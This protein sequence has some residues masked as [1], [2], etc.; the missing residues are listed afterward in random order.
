MVKWIFDRLVSLTA[1]VL[2]SPILLALAVIVLVGN[3]WPIFFR[4]ERIG[5]Y[6]KPFSMIK[7]RSMRGSETSSVATCE[8]E[9]VTSVGRLLRR[10]KLDELP[11]LFNILKGDMSFVG[12]RPDVPGYA[13]KLE[14]DDRKM[15]EMKP[16]LTGVATLKYRNEDDLLSS[17]AN[18]KEYN[19]N[20]IWPDKVRLNLMYQQRQSFCL[21][22]K[23]LL[24]T[25]FGNDIDGFE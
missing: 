14:G 21:D 9:R 3:G 7:F 24:C 12:P 15:L 25:A 19:D 8:K 5:Q 16:G 20:V 11:E 18:P 17:Q 2:L 1:L 13:D 22:I 10:T 4:Q 23:I 6:G